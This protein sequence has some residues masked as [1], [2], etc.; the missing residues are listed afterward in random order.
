[1]TLT[2]SK[3]RAILPVAVHVGGSFFLSIYYSLFSLFMVVKSFSLLA[4]GKFW[5]LNVQRLLYWKQDFVVGLCVAATG[6]CAHCRQE[7]YDQ[8][9]ERIRAEDGQESDEGEVNESCVIATV[10]SVSTASATQDNVCPWLQQHKIMCVHGTL[11]VFNAQ[12]ENRYCLV[13][14]SYSFLLKSSSRFA[15]RRCNQFHCKYVINK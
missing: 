14:F 3:V 10:D 7:V 5:L 15:S 8:G 12:K 6:G 13:S 2:F 1:M 11:V 9:H 4:C